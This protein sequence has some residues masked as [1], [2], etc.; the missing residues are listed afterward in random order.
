MGEEKVVAVVA[1]L[2]DITI[3]FLIGYYDLVVAYR[4]VVA[5][6]VNL[7]AYGTLRAIGVYDAVVENLAAIYAVYM[8]AGIGSSDSEIVGGVARHF[9]VVDVN[10]IQ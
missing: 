4:K 10:G 3:L 5:A 2:N 9:E 1:D 6:P 8:H 7:D